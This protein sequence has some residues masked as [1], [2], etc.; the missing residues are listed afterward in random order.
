VAKTKNGGTAKPAAA[1]RGN[2]KG[3]P[4]RQAA[5]PAPRPTG[6]NIVARSVEHTEADGLRRELAGAETQRLRAAFARGPGPANLPPEQ[7]DEPPPADVQDF[8]LLAGDHVDDTTGQ[9]FEF[10]P[11]EETIVPSPY[12]LDQI[13]MNKFRRV[14]GRTSIGRDYRDN[15]DRPGL[16]DRPLAERFPDGIK[17]QFSTDVEAAEAAREARQARETRPSEDEEGAGASVAD[18]E[19][20]TDKFDKAPAAGLK[21]YHQGRQYHVVEANDPD[22]PLHEDEFTRKDQVE[23]FIDDYSK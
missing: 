5:P 17:S 1:T 20:V 21:V 19:D 22:T 2:S 3:Q 9:R 6:E 18:G 8:V 12:P 13:F 10:V 7:V 14:E 15:W 11:G 4:R 16:G 23:D